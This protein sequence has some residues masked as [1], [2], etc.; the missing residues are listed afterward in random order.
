MPVRLFAGRRLR[1]DCIPAGKSL[2]TG[3]ANVRAMELKPRVNV[4]VNV[5]VDAAGMAQ[6]RILPH[7]RDLV[8]AR[9]VV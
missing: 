5:N 6:A 7:F 3:R 8:R 2:A 1:A 4:N 9:P